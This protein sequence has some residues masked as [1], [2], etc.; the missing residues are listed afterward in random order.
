MVSLLSERYFSDGKCCVEYPNDC[1]EIVNL[2]KLEF[3]LANA[4]SKTFCSLN[5]PPPHVKQQ[6]TR[7]KLEEPI[8]ITTEPHRC[9]AFAD[10]L[11][12]ISQD[13]QEH[14]QCLTQLESTCADLDPILSLKN[15]YLSSMMGR[16]A[17]GARFST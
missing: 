10:D 6:R 7:Q 16:V 5:H 14:R 4:N 1:V 12:I 13:A 11:T 17:T 2:R 3:H 8:V 9:K 15:A